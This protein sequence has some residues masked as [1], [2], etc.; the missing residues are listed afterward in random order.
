TLQLAQR[1]AWV[2]PDAD[3]FRA[4]SAALA[5]WLMDL[6]SRVEE[7][8]TSLLDHADQQDEA[9]ADTGGAGGGAGGG[10]AWQPDIGRLRELFP[11]PLQAPEGDDPSSDPLDPLG[12][13]AGRVRDG[14]LHAL[15][16]VLGSSNPVWNLS[17][18]A[19]PAVPELI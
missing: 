18:K 2:G 13:A 7:Q 14:V 3:G 1:V 10:C 19:L 6:A 15:D 8:G 4:E 12:P 9:S 16:L 17:K 11:W 5:D